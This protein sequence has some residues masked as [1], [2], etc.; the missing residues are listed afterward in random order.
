MTV[1]QQVPNAARVYDF[2]LGGTH[3]RAVDAEAGKAAIALAPFIPDLIRLQ[4]ACL[5]LIAH[6]LTVVRNYSIIVDFASGL[7]T[8]Q[9]LHNHVAPG[10]TVIYSDINADTVAHAQQILADEQATNVHYFQN[11][12]RNPIGFLERPEV[13]VLLQGRR[14]IAMVAWGITLFLDDQTVRHIAQQLHDWASPDA[15]WLMNFPLAGVNAANDA[16]QRFFALYDTIQ[17]PVYPRLVADCAEL[18][19]PWQVDEAGF[20]S[21]M[22]WNQRKPDELAPDVLDAVGPGGGSYGAFLVPR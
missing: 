8:G 18:V 17:E 14:D 16:M 4:H 10:T 12:I 22:E 3:H 13:A 15:C 1:Q 21:I 9:N 11:D 20:T 5:P 19:Q 7:P 2:F 6:E